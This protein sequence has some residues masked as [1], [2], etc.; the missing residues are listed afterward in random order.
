VE[1]GDVAIQVKLGPQVAGRDHSKSP[2][3]SISENL[4]ASVA[5]GKK[6]KALFK[7]L[8]HAAICLVVHS[9]GLNIFL[10]I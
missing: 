3:S 9:T 10:F 4:E 2:I 6:G 8:I 5:V 7:R 1:N